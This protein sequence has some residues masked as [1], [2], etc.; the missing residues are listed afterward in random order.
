[1][2]RRPTCYVIAGPNG[3]G[4]TT[5]ALEFLPRHVG[6]FEFV[7]PDL[8]AQGLSPLNPRTVAFRAGRLVLERIEELGRRRMDFGFETTLS[9]LA[10]LRLLRGLRTAGYRLCLFFIW[11]RSPELAGCRVANRVRMGGHDVPAADRLRRFPRTLRNLGRYGELAE[12]M[13]IFDNSGEMP[14]LVYEKTPAGQKIHD[15]TI[16]AQ[17]AK[18]SDYA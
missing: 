18:E 1:M 9:G 8:I 2:K 14:V 17:I 11:I 7:N 15:A 3:A 12:E 5:F 6:C 10:H 13:F 4:K 16:W